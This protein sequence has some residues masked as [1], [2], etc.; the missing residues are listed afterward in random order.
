MP[1]KLHA[2]SSAPRCG[3]VP[4]ELLDTLRE[5]KWPCSVLPGT[6]I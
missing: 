2:G 3:R 5:R 1:N 6:L 4:G